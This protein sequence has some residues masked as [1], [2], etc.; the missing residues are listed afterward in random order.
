[1][2][3]YASLRYLVC[4]FCKT[5]LDKLFV[6]KCPSEC[7][8]FQLL[9]PIKCIYNW[10]V[11]VERR[12]NWQAHPP[13]LCLLSLQEKKTEISSVNIFD[14]ETIDKETR[15]CENCVQ[16]AEHAAVPRL[17]LQGCHLI[18]SL[19]FGTL[20]QRT[21][22]ATSDIPCWGGYFESFFFS[23]NVCW[24]NWLQ[25]LEVCRGIPF[26]F[27]GKDELRSCLT[28]KFKKKT[29]LI[30]SVHNSSMFLTAV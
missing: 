14:N 18:C 6:R 29:I 1:M 30:V 23:R 24:R 4:W 20:L 10:T 13:S 21:C 25:S 22:K 19:G 17:A 7:E 8:Q 28:S 3:L 27:P 11:N 5:W 12:G 16:Y 26:S 2:L 9:F 15:A